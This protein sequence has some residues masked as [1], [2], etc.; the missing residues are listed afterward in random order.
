MVLHGSVRDLT[1]SDCIFTG[2]NIGLNLYLNQPGRS[3]GLRIRNNTFFNNVS[4]I[5]YGYSELGQKDVIIERN[6]VAGSTQVH[7]G[8]QDLATV[9]R[10]WFR[11]NLWQDAPNDELSG[12]VAKRVEAIRWVSTDETSP[13]YL[14]PADT[15]QVTITE[16][17][18]GRSYHVGAVAPAAP[19]SQ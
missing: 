16:A 19:T 1:I 11:D 10:V 7:P 3:S 18:G 13:D 5:G 15:P 17:D 9:A 8:V 14:R 2:G 6:L 12:L 4:W